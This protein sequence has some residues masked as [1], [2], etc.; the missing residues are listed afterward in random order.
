VISDPPD[1]VQVLEGKPIPIRG[2]A[3]SGDG[4]PITSVDVS[5]DGGRSWIPAA[6]REDQRTQFGWRQWEF[7]W[8]PSQVA[9]YTI[10][11]RARD[12]AGNT[13]PFDQEWNPAGYGWNVVPRVGVDVVK[14]LSVVPQ[15]AQSS[16]SAPLQPVAFQNACLICHEDDVIRQQRLT[17]SQWDREIN[18]MTKW[19]AE[20]KKE[21]RDKILDYLFSNYGPET[22]VR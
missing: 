15:P 3:W 6:L 21:D 11:A 12:V 1:G 7:N 17:R 14:E 5:V 13:Q 2:V 10:L 22:S 19:G 16:G 18:K 4:G 20:M 8:T 9:Y